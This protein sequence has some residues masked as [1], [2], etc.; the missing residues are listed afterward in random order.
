MA[1]ARFA[2]GFVMALLFP[3]SQGAEH[4]F[5]SVIDTNG[6]F[7]S[8]G[9]WGLNNNG[10]VLFQGRKANGATG[11]YTYHAGAVTPAV[12]IGP[13]FSDLGTSSL[14]NSGEVVFYGRLLS[15][16]RGLYTSSAGTISTLYDS[17]GQ[18]VFDSLIGSVPSVNEA[19][20]V[21]FHSRMY[22]GGSGIFSGSGGP[23]T[24][25][26]QTGNMITRQGFPIG[27]L[28]S[29]GPKSLNESGTAAF[30]GNLNTGERGIYTGTGSAVA[31]VVDTSMG[32]YAG[33]AVSLN[34]SG[35][36][37]FS[38]TILS[39]TIGQGAGVFLSHNGTLSLLA[40]SSGDFS[41]FGALDLNEDGDVVV[42]AVLDS[43]HV[44]LFIG[45]D[46]DLDRIIQTGD[47]LFGSVVTSLY[48]GGFPRINDQQQVA[49][50]YS[51]ED[52]RSGIALAV[53]TTA[54]VPLPATIWLL[55]SGL[56]SYL[57]LGISRRRA[58]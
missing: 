55:G 46:P 33:G 43:G 22:S 12:E 54:V 11:L 25:I 16:I 41:D 58:T 2:L 1:S 28:E 34:D 9:L 15:G 52:G 7:G 31:T 20:S 45:A 4:E 38:G 32:I 57:G 3:I 24:T 35:I 26:A 53:P 44:G 40:D 18:Y 37:A 42:M 8:L 50:Y 36:V 48:Q 56:L 29:V 19:G 6:P 21:L 10:Y 5:F 27:F 49:F 47:N 23:V 39:P 17:Q 30:I 13:I 14:S 51:L